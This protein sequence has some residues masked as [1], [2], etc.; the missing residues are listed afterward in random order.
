MVKLI[1]AF[2]TE[3]TKARRQWNDIFKAQ[4]EKKSYQTRILYPA[5]GPSDRKAK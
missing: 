3:T 4:K 1:I 2:S 5:K